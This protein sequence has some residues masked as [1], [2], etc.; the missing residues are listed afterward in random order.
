[1]N[2][3]EIWKSPELVKRYLSGFRNSFPGAIQQIEILSRLIETNAREVDYFL[4]VGCGDGILGSVGLD[5]YPKSKGVFLDFSE[6]MLKAAKE[7]LSEIIDRVEIINCDYGKKDWVEKVDH[8]APYDIIVSGYSIHHQPDERKKEIYQE[9][10][11]LL[12][13]G[14]LFI[15]IDHVLSR[16][17]WGESVHNENFID[18]LYNYEIEI[19]TEISR[20]EVI[21]NYYNRE[22]KSANILALVEEQCD[23]LRDVGFTDVDCYHKIFELAVFGGRK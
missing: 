11:D 23:W 22:D 19:G 13:R 1:M 18:A 2:N 7:K 6:D 9:I 21:D 3:Y 16:S 15:N 17:T 12:P 10:F 4:D 8:W 5:K 20:K 14:G